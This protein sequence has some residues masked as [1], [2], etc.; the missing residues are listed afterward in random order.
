MPKTQIKKPASAGFLIEQKDL[1]LFT[2]KYRK[3]RV[4]WACRAKLIFIIDD[5][6]DFITQTLT[7]VD[8]ILAIGN[9]GLGWIHHFTATEN[10]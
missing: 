10:A 1:G 5:H 8:L 4:G 3:T 7:E 2:R 6:Q 9:K